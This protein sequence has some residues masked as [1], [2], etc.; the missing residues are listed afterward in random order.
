VDAFEAELVEQ[1]VVEQGQV[2][3]A[4][5]P[6]RQRG[7][8]ETGLLGRDEITALRHHLVERDPHAGKTGAV[9]QHDGLALA[10]APIG[11]R[12]AGDRFEGGRRVIA[13]RF[14]YLDLVDDVDVAHGDSR[15]VG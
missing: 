12:Q 14:G 8:A 2:V 4:A 3:E 13:W 10:G 9:Q 5:E 7:L 11:Y 15:G 1:L 6:F